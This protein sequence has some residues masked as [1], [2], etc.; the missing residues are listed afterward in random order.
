MPLE[1]IDDADLSS[2]L[3]LRLS[4]RVERLI[5]VH[6]P[7]EL[8]EARQ[9]LRGPFRGILGQGTNSVL[10]SSIRGTL[11]QPAW[12]GLSRL[13]DLRIEAGAGLAWDDLVAWSLGQELYG[14]ENLSMIPGSVGAAP[15]QNIGA[16]GVELADCLESLDALDWES[17]SMRRFEHA[18]CGFA[19]RD[20]VFRKSGAGRWVILRLRLRLRREGVRLSHPD[21][22]A[23]FAHHPQASA[24]EVAEAVR[25]IRSRK[26]PDPGDHP[27]VGSFFHN[28]LVPPEEAM[29][30]LRQEP[31]LVHAVDSSG[32]VKLSAAWMIERCGLKGMRQGNVGVSGQHALVLV[33]YSAATGEELIAFAEQVRTAVHERFGLRLSIEPRVMLD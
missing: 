6:H 15:V 31:K 28:P 32:K 24:L 26:L 5:R 25:S 17:G 21:L 2:H 12:Q 33:N 19:Y 14:L 20:S 23:A 11:V 18:D 1:I 8:P 4:A 10:G 30:L 27:N 9:A 16:Y 7:A 13:D 22:A 3:S 29:K